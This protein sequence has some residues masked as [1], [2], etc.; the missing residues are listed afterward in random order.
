MMAEKMENLEAKFLKVIM[1]VDDEINKVYTHWNTALVGK[2][3]SKGF[4]IEFI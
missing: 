2:F 1:F 3:L 4:P